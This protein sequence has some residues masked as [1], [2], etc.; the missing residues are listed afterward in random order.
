MTTMTRLIMWRLLISSLLARL[1]PAARGP[2]IL[3]KGRRQQ[4]AVVHRDP[5]LTQ[6]HTGR[7]VLHPW[8]ND[9]GPHCL[10]QSV[11]AIGEESLTVAPDVSA[12]VYFMRHGQNIGNERVDTN[13]E[14]GL[15]MLSFRDGMLTQTGI[16]QAVFGRTILAEYL[17]LT[18]Q[19]ASSVQLVASPLSRAFDT[20]TIATSP[21]WH[22]W[23]FKG[24]YHR[25]HAVPAAMEMDTTP[26]S[27]RKP[28]VQDDDP[29]RWEDSVLSTE[30]SQMAKIAKYPGAECFYQTAADREDHPNVTAKPVQVQT[31]YERKPEPCDLGVCS[32]QQFDNLLMYL[33]STAVDGKKHIVVGSH[34]CVIA[35][36]MIRF[37]QNKTGMGFLPEYNST[38]EYSAPIPNGAVL[39]TT[40]KISYESGEQAPRT[41]FVPHK[42]YQSQVWTT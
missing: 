6:L 22:A 37:G 1:I 30:V 7:T 19:P 29:V 16:N 23:N 5:L 33:T 26:N 40:L 17:G 13:K 8:K 27:Q 25:L 15:S 21:L 4:D 20:L 18:K 35:C 12:E 10:L 34:G 14:G 3:N 31:F 24:D 9:T 11:V 41:T 42:L 32:S 39:H 2:N 28:G 36:M 38:I